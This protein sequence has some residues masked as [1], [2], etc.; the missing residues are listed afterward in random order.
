[1]N[2]QQRAKKNK[3]IHQPHS[4]NYFSA[5]DA[6][7]G[8]DSS[9]REDPLQSS[10]SPKTPAASQ[11]PLPK[12]PES[13]QNEHLTPVAGRPLPKPPKPEVHLTHLS[14]QSLKASV[15]VTHQL[16]EVSNQKPQYCSSQ[17]KQKHVRISEKITVVVSLA[18]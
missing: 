3:L 16:S 1:M 5:L 9:I 2:K 12:V 17:K 10:S 18:V 11:R 15:P 4:Y 13:S 8:V 7:Y 14:S 6:I